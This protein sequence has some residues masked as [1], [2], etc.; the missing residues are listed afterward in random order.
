MLSFFPRTAWVSRKKRSF[1]A[2]LPFSVLFWPKKA[3]FPCFRFFYLLFFCQNCVFGAPK[4]PFHYEKS[5]ARNDTKKAQEQNK[6]RK[7][8]LGKY[9]KSFRNFFNWIFRAGQ[10]NVKKVSKIFL[11]GGNSAL[12]IGVLVKTNFEASKSLYLRAFQSLKNCLD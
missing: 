6:H 8:D 10:E 3:P 1:C 12:V 2:F 11:D 9:H 4:C 5:E 7:G